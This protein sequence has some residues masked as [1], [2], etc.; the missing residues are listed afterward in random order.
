MECSS[1][2]AVVLLFNFLDIC[3]IIVRTKSKVRLTS[4]LYPVLTYSR[5]SN[6]RVGWNKRAGW[7]IHANLGNF[8]NLTVFKMDLSCF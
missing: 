2:F 6:K 1:F 4:Y 8:L 3:C 5:V 7:K